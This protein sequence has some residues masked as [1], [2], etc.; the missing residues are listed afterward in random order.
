MNAETAGSGAADPR[1]FFAAE[2][3]LLAW[4]RTGITLMAF[5]FVIARFGLFLDLLAHQNIAATPRE[6]PRVSAIIGVLL[7]LGGAL[8]AL[9]AT[10]QHHRFVAT[11]APSQLPARYSLWFALFTGWLL[12]LLGLVLAAYLAVT[13]FLV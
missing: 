4:L 8:A 12:A 3:T 5:G 13:E 9:G 2:R 7:M 11:L 10:L 6:Y 1:I